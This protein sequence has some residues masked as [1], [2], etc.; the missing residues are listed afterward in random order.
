[1]NSALWK[2]GIAG[3]VVLFVYSA[4][5][6]MVMPWNEG[7]L[8][9]FPDESAVRA[10]ISAIKTRGVYMMPMGEQDAAANPQGPMVFAA[11]APGPMASMGPSMAIGFVNDVICALI[12]AW[13]LLR[14]PGQTYWGKV[15]LVVAIGLAG[16]L[17]VHVNYWNWMGF[18]GHYTLV[19]LLD[20]TVGWLLAALAMAR[21]AR[22]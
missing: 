14:I 9:G 12:A 20:N 7:S 6:W 18:A 3:G 22:L 2:A 17:M 8:Q 11:V 10:S 21:L 4:I 16:S 13:I 19:Q 1:M 5:S 15:C